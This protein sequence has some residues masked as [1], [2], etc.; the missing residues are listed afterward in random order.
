MIDEIKYYG[1][2]NFITDG[3]VLAH[4]KPIS[5]ETRIDIAVGISEKGIL[6]CDKKKAYVI[7]VLSVD[8]TDNH[9]NILRDILIVFGVQTNVE[10]LI[11]LKTKKSVVS[12]FEEKLAT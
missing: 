8:A 12:F 7:L 1:P 2:Y 5:N 6:F 3:V 4:A 9:L 11:A 10:Q